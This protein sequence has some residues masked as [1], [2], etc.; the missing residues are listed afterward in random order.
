L[1][2]I[3]GRVRTWARP[4]LWFG[5]HIV[6][7]KNRRED[8]DRRLREAMPIKLL[9]FQRLM[10]LPRATGIQ[11]CWRKIAMKT[12]PHFNVLIASVLST[13]LVLCGCHGNQQVSANASTQPDQPSGDPASANL[14]PVADSSAAPAPE[15]PTYAGG[16]YSGAPVPSSV[17]ADAQNYPPQD[18]YPPEYDGEYSSQG[19]DTPDESYYGVEPLAT[20]PEPPPPLPDY[21]QPPCPGDGYL[22]TPGY[23]DYASTG[24]YWVPGMWVEA[25]YVGAL[26]TPGYWGYSH[27]HYAFFHGYWGPHIGFYGGVNYGFGYAGVGYQGGYWNGGRFDYNRSVNNVNVTV[28]HNVYN[29]TIANNSAI[30]RNNRVSYNGGRGGISTR[31][32]P[33]E[34]AALREP[35]AAPMQT[36]LTVQRSASENRAQFASVNR[37]RPTEV[38]DSRPVSREA[39][40][41]PEASTN[42]H[43]LPMAARPPMSARNNNMPANRPQGN[44]VQPGRPEAQQGRPE[45][46]HE[47]GN[48]PQPP[49]EQRN[50]QVEQ[51]NRPQPNPQQANRPQQNY[52]QPNRPE[53]N[54]REQSR[55]QNQPQNQPQPMRAQPEPGR[56]EQY[57][58][59]QPPNAARTAPN[60]PEMQPQRQPAPPQPRPEMRPLHPT[61]PRP[62]PDHQ[63]QF[64][65]AP[66]QNRPAPQENRPAP[67]EHRPA[68]QPQSH[69]APPAK[70][71]EPAH[72]PPAQGH[73]DEHRPH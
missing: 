38:V 50:R 48:R 62:E 22:W 9:T 8:A 26:W 42:I 56:Q 47:Q 57:H 36:Q 55:P 60:R 53:P 10:D 66:Q 1:L 44:P 37:G 34:L 32:R 46:S 70:A 63:A 30:T 58:P 12:F 6:L 45:M 16:A 17:P 54:Y 4:L 51:P 28:V 68:P 72:N 33:A 41:R 40:V 24:Y 39:N 65:P 19:D 69:A 13:G 23:W 2:E 3:E 7:G 25:P 73:E 14:A 27:G 5:A 20:A 29:R 67:E 43:N 52:G 15:G 59:A 11:R 35:H 49:V 61:P 21:D 71:P 64:H 31:P 18:A